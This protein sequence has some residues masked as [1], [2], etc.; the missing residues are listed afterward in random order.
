MSA[1]AKDFKNQTREES[2]NSIKRF[3]LYGFFILGFIATLI[4]MY[5][6]KAGS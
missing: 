3:K 4:V 2:V 6:L 5:L 1:Q